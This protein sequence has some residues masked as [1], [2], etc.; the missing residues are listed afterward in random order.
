M[1]AVTPAPAVA[2]ASLNRVSGRAAA[3]RSLIGGCLLGAAIVAGVAFGRSIEA[4]PGDGSAEAGFARDMATH[5]DQAV[6]MSMIALER[7]EDPLVAGLAKDILLTQQNQ[8]GQM[9]GWL[10]VWDVPPTGSEP[11]MTWMGHE[12]AERMPG[13]ASPAEVAGLAGLTGGDLDREFLRLMIRHHEGGAPMAR[14]ILDRSENDAVREL[15]STILVSQ[16]AEV[17]TMQRLLAA[18]NGSIPRYA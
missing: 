5:H 17:A 4:T 6:A 12:V 10:H 3:W 14:A 9:L 18:R 13:L 15:A 11:P 7:S 16:Q 8:I 1:S 2:E